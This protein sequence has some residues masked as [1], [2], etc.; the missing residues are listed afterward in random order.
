MCG[1]YP[2]ALDD[3][4]NDQRLKPILGKGV[5]TFVCLQDEYDNHIPEEVWRNGVGLRPYYE[6]AQRLTKKELL[7]IQLPIVDG[8][9]APDDTTAQLIVL[10]AEKMMEGRMLYMHCFGGHGRAGVFAC[11]MLAYLY[12]IT[13][14]E[15][16]KRIQAYHD[17]RI[18]HQGAKSPQTVVQRDQVKRQVYSL[19]KCEAPAVSIKADL[20]PVDGG[21]DAAKRGGMKPMT[22]SS[23]CPALKEPR[24]SK[25]GHTPTKQLTPTGSVVHPNA[26]PD[27]LLLPTMSVASAK[28][29]RDAAMRQKSAAAALR[30]KKFS[31]GRALADEAGVFLLEF[32]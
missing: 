8:G 20:L 32:R 22:K 29:R 25:S 3:R 23:S 7:W 31:K 6:D 12:R 19:L 15:A 1:P 27:F 2:G 21:M 28:L 26:M 24:E 4:R 14:S 5:D 9:I 11:L 18:D 10:L 16:M 30:R 13:A 17:C